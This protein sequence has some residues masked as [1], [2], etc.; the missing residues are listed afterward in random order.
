MMA[1]KEICG[2]MTCQDSCSVSRNLSKIFTSCHESWQD[3]RQDQADILAARNLILRKNLGEF[4]SRI[5]PRFWPL[6]ICFSA[7]ILASFATGSQQDFCHRDF[8]FL[9]RILVRFAAGS[10]WDFDHRDSCFPA[11]ILARFMT[12]SLQDFG[13]REFPFLA[14]ILPGSAH[15]KWK[16]RLPKSR[17]DPSRIPP[18]SRSLFYKGDS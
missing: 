7:R 8:C 1:P 6:G 14:R 13:R 11:R 18:T 12:W 10:C 5:V 16:S 15:W 2:S 17:Q 4:H 9:V 3:S